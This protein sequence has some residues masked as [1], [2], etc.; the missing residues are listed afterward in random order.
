MREG[1]EKSSAS[2]IIYHVLHASMCCAWSTAWECL[3]G[4]WC[5]IAS[6]WGIRGPASWDLQDIDEYHRCS[7]LT[8]L[9]PP[10][11]H[12]RSSSHW[13]VRKVVDGF[14]QVPCTG[15][16]LCS[17]LSFLNWG[18]VFMFLHE[19]S[20]CSFILMRVW[21]SMFWLEC[22]KC[23]LHRLSGVL[24]V[25]V[26]NRMIWSGPPCPCIVYDVSIPFLCSFHVVLC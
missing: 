4:W 14:L 16:V 1:F 3:H 21:I 20:P 5:M 7:H 26:A 15:F 2:Y 23:F 22:V 19:Q 11:C 8:L 17:S 18:L 24:V 9:L 25:F 13:N 10:I 6:F 12:M